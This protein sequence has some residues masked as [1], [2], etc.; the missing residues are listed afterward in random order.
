[1]NHKRGVM[2]LVAAFLFIFLFGF[3]WHGILM[4]PYYTQM[5]EHWRATPVFGWLVLG[6]ALLAFAFTVLYINKIGVH[7]VGS[8]FGFGIFIA[9]FA[10][11]ADII[12][13]ATEPLSGTVVCLWIIGLLIQFGVTGA[14]V[15]AIYK[16]LP[17]TAAERS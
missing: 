8:G 11:G 10:A 4:K 13:F 2:A 14:I 15:G 17:S 12:R 5:P 7:G 6:H 1:M 16:P 9:I 3:L